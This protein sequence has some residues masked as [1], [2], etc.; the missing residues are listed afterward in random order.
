MFVR[1]AKKFLPLFKENTTLKTA[2]Y[3]ARYYNFIN[4]ICFTSIIKLFTK[5]KFSDN[6]SIFRG[7][8]QHRP[9]LNTV[10]YCLHIIKLV[11]YTA[12]YL[13]IIKKI[14]KIL[15]SQKN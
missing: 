13:H 1:A 7:A 2:I 4:L 6:A 9:A 14:I 3:A 10:A 12:N 5:P 11:L 8:N 15:K